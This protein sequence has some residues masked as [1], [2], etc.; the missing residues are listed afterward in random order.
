[1]SGCYQNNYFAEV[2]ASRSISRVYGSWDDIC[3]VPYSGPKHYGPDGCA[4]AWHVGAGYYIHV[5]P[6]FE[7]CLDAPMCIPNGSM[8]AA[9]FQPYSD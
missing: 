9:A 7:Y 8:Q 4:E 2:V 3:V 1:M 6:G 5:A